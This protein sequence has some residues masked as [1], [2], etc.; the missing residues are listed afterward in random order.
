MI[1]NGN[2]YIIG[3]IEKK[4]WIAEN[5]REINLKHWKNKKIIKI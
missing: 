3:K 1:K 2:T 5:L 4:F